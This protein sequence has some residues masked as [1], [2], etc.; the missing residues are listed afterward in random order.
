ME[1]SPP[2]LTARDFIHLLSDV[3]A[4]GKRNMFGWLKRLFGPKEPLLVEREFASSVAGVTFQNRDR[5]SRQ[6]IIRERVYRGM[7]LALVFEDDNPKD[8]SAVALMIP[9]GE[10][11]GYLNTR[12]AG[13]ARAWTA[14][15][16]QIKV[17]V[18]EVTGGAEDKPTCGVNIW[19]T[20]YEA[21]DRAAGY[22][23]V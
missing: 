19:V 6:K 17:Q 2:R 8:K 7:M 11:I 20:V 4:K 5:K 9:T 21:P 3:E 16:L 14:E 22:A 23:S 10:Q 12:L 15:G 13:D 1:T 18:T